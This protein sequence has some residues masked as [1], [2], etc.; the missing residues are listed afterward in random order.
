MAGIDAFGTQLKI[1]D[2]AGTSYDAVA[3]VTNVDVLD[4]QVEDIETSHDSPNQWREYIG[5]LKDGGELSFELNF[6][7]AVH[8][9]LL[10]LVGET[11]E[12]QI[13]MPA[14]VDDLVDFEGYIKSL[15]AAAPYDGKL[16][17]TASIKV[18]GPVTI[19]IT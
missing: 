18:S 12:M 7:P 8:A 1:G 2:A 6:D 4:V 17:A 13:V 11:R 15:G 16:T 5:G 3:E 10:D 19:T 14:G 9:T